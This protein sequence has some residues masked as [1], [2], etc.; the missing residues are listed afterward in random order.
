MARH[1]F[2]VGREHRELYEFLVMQFRGDANVRV[3][4]DRRHGQRRGEASAGSSPE[5]ERRRRPDRRTRRSVDEELRSRS[6][7]IISLPD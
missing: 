5:A 2:I 6:H 1:L 4:L 3:I 7:A